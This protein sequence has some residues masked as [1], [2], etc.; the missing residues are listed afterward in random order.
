MSNQNVISK[1]ELDTDRIDYDSEAR[2]F[3]HIFTKDVM[4]ASQLPKGVNVINELGEITD[5]PTYMHQEILNDHI[6]DDD[7]AYKLID[8]F[9]S[10]G[11]D[12]QLVHD[13]A[14]TFD[15]ECDI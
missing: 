9:I 11:A 15:V 8:M 12:D 1:V 14:E 4:E 6:I 10:Q 2:T 13:M 3:K 7:A 5:I